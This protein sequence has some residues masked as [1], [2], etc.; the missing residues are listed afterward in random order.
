MIRAIRRL[1]FVTVLWAALNVALPLGVSYADAVLAGRGSASEA[2]AHVEEK[3]GPHCQPVHA[4]ECVLCR[5][6]SSAAGELRSGMG[7]ALPAVVRVEI[8]LA[9]TLRIATSTVA[10]TRSRAPPVV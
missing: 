2:F 10:G 6:L 3:S 7:A 4:D 5:F 9:P 8:P 1:R